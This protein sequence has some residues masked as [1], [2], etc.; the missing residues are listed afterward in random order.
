MGP[1][2]M[3]FELLSIMAENSAAC[4]QGKRKKAFKETTVKTMKIGDYEKLAQE[5]SCMN[6]ASWCPRLH[7]ARTHCGRARAAVY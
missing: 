1:G 4:S 3:N 6:T 5:T 7:S 2:L